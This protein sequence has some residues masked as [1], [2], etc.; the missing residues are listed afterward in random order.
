M[1]CFAID[2]DGTLLNKEH[3]ISD[4]NQAAIKKRQERGDV[5]II[6]TGRAAFDARRI[7]AQ[8][9]LDCPVIGANG[10]EVEVG[11]GRRCFLNR[12]SSR[13]IWEIV[14][15]TNVF[16]HIYLQDNILLPQFSLAALQ[17]GDRAF[18]EAIQVQLTQYGVEEV[19]EIAI[20][21][22]DV[23]KFMFVSPDRWR[24]E[25]LE[26][27][28]LQ[29]KICSVTRSGAYNLEVMANGV[30]KGIALKD[31]ARAYGMTTEDIIA[32]GDN[33]NDLPMF[34]VAGTSI[35]MGN[36]KA[37][38]KSR[39]TYLTSDHDEDGVAKALND[40]ERWEQTKEEQHSEHLG[41]R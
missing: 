3:G 37:S 11:Q 18:Q 16:I 1:R 33:Q 30:T 10:A 17:G 8:H 39:A 7:L 35:A 12:S 34:E 14:R 19:D 4:A 20:D 28:L 26:Q 9:G 40:L 27:Q 6:V 5:V 25:H 29:L 38:V 32:I 24:L 23:I 2:L 22:L 15:S 36:A 31:I 13:T 41:H 21:Q